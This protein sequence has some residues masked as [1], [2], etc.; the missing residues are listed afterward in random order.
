MVS[1]I[2][3][4]GRIKFLFSNCD[5]THKAFAIY[6]NMLIYKS[7]HLE[8]NLARGHPLKLERYREDQHGPCA[9]MTRTNRECITFF[10]IV[11]GGGLN[12]FFDR[13]HEFLKETTF[14]GIF[15]FLNCH[16]YLDKESKKRRIGE[17]PTLLLV[18]MPPPPNKKCQQRDSNKRQT[19]L[20]RM[21]SSLHNRAELRLRP[22]GFC[23]L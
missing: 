8:W 2:S 11:Y 6:K 19:F 15:V 9:R 21:C 13:N 12:L 5:C 1:N 20:S 3:F 10:A 17:N 4:F 18:K 7:I 14:F 16:C 22:Q 23:N